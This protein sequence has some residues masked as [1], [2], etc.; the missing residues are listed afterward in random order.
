MAIMRTSIHGRRLGLSSTGGIIQGLT[1]TGGGSSEFNLHTQMWGSA[2]VETVSS[3]GAV[4]SNS[5]VSIVSSNSTSGASFAVAAPVSGVYKEIHFQTPATAHTLGTTST[6]IWFNSTLGEAAAGGST[7]LTVAG[8]TLGIGGS[9]VLRGLS[10]SVWSI[11][12]H[13]ANVSS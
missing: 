2:M 6:T 12:G 5:G 8:S 9:L 13:T 7:T 1:S 11:I 3:A 10:A 4:M